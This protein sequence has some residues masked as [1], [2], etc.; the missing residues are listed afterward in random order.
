MSI[1]QAYSLA[2]T[3]ISRIINTGLALIILAI[4]ARYF[5]ARLP[6]PT[7]SPT[8]LAYL[9]GAWWLSRK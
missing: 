1:D 4:V 3:W 8:E 6:I 9:A 2:M 5:G 7:P